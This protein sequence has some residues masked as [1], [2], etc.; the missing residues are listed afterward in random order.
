[1]IYGSYH[2]ESP[3][4]A[5]TIAKYLKGKYRVDA[6]GGH[7][8]DLPKNAWAWISKTILSLLTVINPGQ[9]A[10]DQAACRPRRPRRKTSISRPDPDREG[11]AISWHLKNV[12]KLKDGKYRIE[13]NEISPS[14]VNKA[15]Q[16]PREIDQNLVDAQQARRVLDR[17][18]G[19]KLSPL[20]VKRIRTG[21]SAG[22]VQ[23]VALRL[24]VDREREIRA[25]VPEEY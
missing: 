11:E 16:N 22:R 17:L 19:Y 1:M 15:L 21:L 24:I 4:K 13:F 20:L 10:G 12:L 3:S 9:K 25:F 7:V 23:S 8:R 18:V 14:A 2:R 6:S 5:K